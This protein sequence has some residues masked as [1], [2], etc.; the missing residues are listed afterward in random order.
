MTLVIRIAIVL[1][2]AMVSS[3]AQ[4]AERPD[5]TMS[6]YFYVPSGNPELP[7][8]E[9]RAKVDIAGV[10][11]KVVVTQVYVNLWVAQG[12]AVEEAAGVRLARAAMERLDTEAWQEQDTVSPEGAKLSP[13]LSG[14]E[15][16]W[17]RGLYPKRLSADICAENSDGSDIVTKWG[18]SRT[19]SFK[20]Q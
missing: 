19:R 5:K 1:S 9:T 3:F 16:A 20:A 4:A 7:L 15:I 11:A 10:V 12:W 8:K 14:L 18:L 6:P 2:F 17:F 13:L